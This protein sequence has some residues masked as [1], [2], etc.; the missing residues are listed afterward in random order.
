MNVNLNLIDIKTKA[1]LDLCMTD[2]HSSLFS[3]DIISEDAVLKW[4]RES[5]S[6]KGKSVFLEQM[7]KFVEWLQNAEEGGFV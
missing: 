5:H 1:K 2:S 3:V 7:K 4:Y 6:A